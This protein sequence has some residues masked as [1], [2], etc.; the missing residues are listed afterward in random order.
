MISWRRE[1][2]TEVVKC[3]SFPRYALKE[4]HSPPECGDR[5]K[6]KASTSDIK[7][8]VEQIIASVTCFTKCLHSST[9]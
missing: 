1:D 5:V 3:E 8:S 9:R 2:K 7:H 4:S 6:I